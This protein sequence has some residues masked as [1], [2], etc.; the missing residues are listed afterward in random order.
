L[1]DIKEWC[2]E[3]IQTLNKKAQDRGTW[4]MVVKR[5]WTPAGAEPIE[6]WIDG[7]GL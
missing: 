6:Q 7:V 1:Y 3:E 2:G 4:R 5:Q